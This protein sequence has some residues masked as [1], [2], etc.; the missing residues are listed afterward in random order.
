M[1]PPQKLPVSVCIIAGNEAHR[2]TPTLQSVADWA[3]EIIVVI[4][5]DVN[6]GTDRIVESFGGKVFREPWKGNIEQNRSASERLIATGCS[7]ST[8]TKLFRRNLRTR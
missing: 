7:R 6:D 5:H 4:N 1:N 2:I 3:D 8:P